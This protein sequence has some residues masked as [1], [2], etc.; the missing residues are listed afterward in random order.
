M[1]YK[2]K[3]L[4]A[5]ARVQLSGKYGIYIGAYLLAAVI[6]FTVS[7]ILSMI[8]SSSSLLAI[9]YSDDL[10]SSGN[11]T[12]LI[13]YLLIEFIINLILSVLMLGFNKMF[14]DGSRGYEVHFED[15]FYGFRH[16]PDRVILMQLLMGLINLACILPGYVIMICALYFDTSFILV[17]FGI[18]LLIAGGILMIYFSLA[19]SQSMYLMADYDD[20]GPVQTLKESQKMMSGNKGRYLYMELSFIGFL[21]LSLLTCYI[22]L[23][24]V[25]PYMSM[26]ATNFYRNIGG[27]I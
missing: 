1:K 26:T 17:L 9:F 2:T 7:M 21:L 3:D 11:I 8:N 19:F 22:G 27:E 16:H 10:F 14:L 15:L 25:M 4:K 23:L 13:T 6:Q 24:W 5:M 20:L 12:R 18:L